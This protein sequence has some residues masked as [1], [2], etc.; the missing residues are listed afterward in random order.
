[1]ASPMSFPRVLAAALASS[2]VV[3]CSAA[4]PEGPST[5]AGGPWAQAPGSMEAPST[6]AGAPMPAAP[7]AAIVGSAAPADAGVPESIAPDAAT[8]RGGGILSVLGGG[9]TPGEVSAMWGDTDLSSAVD[10]VDGEADVVGAGGLGTPGAGHGKGTGGLR[11]SHTPGSRG[12]AGPDDVRAGL[13]REVIRRIVQATLPRIQLCY[14]TAL[15]RKP[16]L[17]GKLSIRFEIARTGAV[18]STRAHVDEV[19]DEELVGCVMRVFGDMR[20]PKPDGKAVR[21]VYPLV[22]HP[23]PTAPRP[24]ATPAPPPGK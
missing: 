10:G 15:A 1:M 12:G 22:F 13:P 2:A 18:V 11:G 17:A 20:F 8:P 4:A 14:E 16:T 7:S 24:P 23:E 9:R 21:V 3:A 5:A 6:A 19:Q